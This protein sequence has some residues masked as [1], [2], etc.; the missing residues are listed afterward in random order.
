MRKRELEVTNEQVIRGILD[1][2]K[3][4]HLGLSDDGQPYV[5]PMNYGYVYENGRLVLYI[6]GAVAG[7]K[8]EVIRK[9][10]KVSFSM[11]CDLKPFDGRIPCQYGMAYSSIL[12][13]GTAE[14]VYD[15]EEKINALAILM[16]TQTGKDF[17]FREKLVSIVNVVKITVSEFSAKQRPLPGTHESVE[18]QLD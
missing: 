16:K 18:A 13:I 7:Y 10:P 11:E 14:I 3:V 4:M 8:Y 17:E 9:N 2:S 15:V 5:V 1:R 12:G 6:H